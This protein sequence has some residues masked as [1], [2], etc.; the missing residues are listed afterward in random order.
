MALT[1]KEIQ[2]IIDTYLELKSQERTAKAL[3]RSLNTVRKYLAATGHGVGR[4]GNQAAQMKMTDAELADAI[5]AGLTRAE[6]AEKFGLHIA[7]LDRRMRNLG[8][9]ARHAVPKS[10]YISELHEWHETAGSKRLVEEKVGER[11]R[12]VAYKDHKVKLRCKACGTFVETTLKTV[13]RAVITCPSCKEAKERAQAIQKLAATILNIVESKTPKKCVMCGSTFYSPYA[14][15]IYCS[16]KCSKKA[17]N[18]RKLANR[19]K[20]GIKKRQHG[21]TYRERCMKHNTVYVPGITLKRIYNRDRGI[22]Q[23][24]GK[25][26]DWNDKS[27]GCGYGPLYPSIDH[28]VALANGGGH[29]LDN[30]QLAHVLCNALKSDTREEAGRYA[31]E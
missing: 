29:T 25:P 11:F 21:R 16:E 6:I 26:T 18:K 24:C 3:H 12:Y 22:C 13:T 1:G 5:D 10:Q 30:V 31:K 9:Y 20:R 28:I 8:K 19:K 7:N 27:Y 15:K 4:G 17:K 14:D 23:I 2:E